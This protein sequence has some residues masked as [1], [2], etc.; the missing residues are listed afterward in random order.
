[1][2]SRSLV[3]FNEGRQSEKRFRERQRSRLLRWSRDRRDRS[4][5]FVTMKGK[6][7]SAVQGPRKSPFRG[8][9]PKIGRGFGSPALKKRPGGSLNQRNPI[10]KAGRGQKCWDGAL[11]HALGRETRKVEQLFW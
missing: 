1:M 4:E 5:G 6:T 3:N 2:E 11:G 8:G 9:R 10:E 7:R